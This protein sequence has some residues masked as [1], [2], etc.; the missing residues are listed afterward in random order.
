M[1]LVLP[2]CFIKLDFGFVH[3]YDQYNVHL[4]AEISNEEI[5]MACWYI[6]FCGQRNLVQPMDIYRSF[7][8]IGGENFRGVD[9]GIDIC[10]E[11]LNEQELTKISEWVIQ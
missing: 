2:D 5:S 7:N 9:K 1:W 3:L 8:T 11:T 6:H 10:V 4:E